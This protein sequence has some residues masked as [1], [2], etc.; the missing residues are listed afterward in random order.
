MK[1]GLLVVLLTVFGTVL[2][3]QEKRIEKNVSKEVNMEEINGE[4]VLT[5]ILT[6][7]DTKTYE[8]Y[9]GAE[10]EVKFKELEASMRPKTKN[11]EVFVTEE[12][13]V[14][15]VRIQSTE[16][17]VVNEEVFTGEKANAKLKELGLNEN[18]KKAEIKQ[19]TIIEQRE[20]KKGE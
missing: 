2:Y 18:T 1:K 6:D 9:K 8:V 4:L 17:G 10:A 19:E 7:G 14:K 13:G 3:A 20:L 5:V 11:E 12:N 15:T 16:N